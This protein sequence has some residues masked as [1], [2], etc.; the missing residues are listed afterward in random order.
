MSRCARH[1]PLL[2][3]PAPAALGRGSPC[4]SLLPMHSLSLSTLYIRSNRND[5]SFLRRREKL[6]F[7][8]DTVCLERPGKVQDIRLL[9]NI[10]QSFLSYRI[11]ELP[12]NVLLQWDV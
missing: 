6:L 9:N 1:Q 2:A 11:Y 5:L 10:T 12:L 8:V 7:H 3:Y 4:L